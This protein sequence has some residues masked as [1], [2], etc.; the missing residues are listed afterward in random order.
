ML[1]NS[2]PSAD[3][4]ICLSLGL[5][6]EWQ[7]VLTRAEHLPPGQTAADVL[8]FVRFLA[9]QARLQEVFFRWRPYLR[10]PDD[11]MIVELALAAQSQYIVTHNLRDF[12]GCEQ[13]G[14]EAISPG[15]FLKLLADQTNHERGD[16]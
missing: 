14:I 2:I 10:D 9:N 7:D 4:K 16:N 15:D 11:D 13:L 1:V 5:Y 12:A 3:F 8:A 6:L